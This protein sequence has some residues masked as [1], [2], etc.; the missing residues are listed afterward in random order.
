MIVRAPRRSFPTHVALLA[1]LSCAFVCTAFVSGVRAQ[2]PPSTKPADDAPK[3]RTFTSSDGKTLPYL[4]LKP[5][6]F[7]PAKK[8]PL[9]MSSDITSDSFLRYFP[10]ASIGSGRLAYIRLR[11]ATQYVLNR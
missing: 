1:A 3:P 8:Y 10:A 2:D 5:K 7:D 6:D 9:V 4:L 11:I